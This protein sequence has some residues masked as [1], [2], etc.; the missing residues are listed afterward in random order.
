MTTPSPPDHHD[1]FQQRVLLCVAA[2]PVARVATYGQIA[3]LAGHARA[4]RRVGAILRALPEDTR[5]PWY[6]VVNRLGTL[7]LQGDAFLRQ[8]RALQAE[9]IAVDEQGVLDLAR[10]R[11]HP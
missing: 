6:R 5:L 2:I 3:A 11:W 4:A 7:S 8:R 10:W 9:G 1:T